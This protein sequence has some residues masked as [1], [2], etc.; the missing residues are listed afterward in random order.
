[1]VYCESGPTEE[2]EGK[3]GEEKKREEVQTQSRVARGPNIIHAWF[4]IERVFWVDVWCE[5]EC[6]AAINV[7]N[8]TE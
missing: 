2:E 7:S 3:E 6:G 1:M 5:C 8:N 4:R